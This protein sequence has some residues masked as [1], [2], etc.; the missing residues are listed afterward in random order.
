MIEPLYQAVTGKLTRV[1]PHGDWVGRWASSGWEEQSEGGT[2]M[3]SGEDAMAGWY[4]NAKMM[5]TL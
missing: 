1:V 5:E 3:K 2:R 4:R